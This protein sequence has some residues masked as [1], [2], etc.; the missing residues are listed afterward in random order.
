MI[1]SSRRPASQWLVYAGLAIGSG[2]L[3]LGSALHRIPFEWAETLGFITRAWGVWLQVREN[4]WNWPVQ[5]VSSAIY[6]FVFLQARLY[7]DTLLNVL[8]VGLYVLGWY[9]W[10][11]G[12]E[13][14]TVLHVGRTSARLAIALSV[15][16][17]AGTVAWT[18]VLMR[19]ND[20]APLLDAFTTALSLV[21]LLLTAR[22][23]YESWLV[24]IFVNV[25][26]VG[27]YTN[28]GLY[29]TAVLY[30]IFA[31]LSVAGLFNWRRLLHGQEA[32]GAVP[33]A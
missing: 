12:G 9:W 2:A 21:A 24:W 28:K 4:V 25:V 13:G 32:A 29:L 33:V 17:I 5:L 11:R 30:A 20:S 15:A 6:V 26:F 1:A 27:L 3:A 23:L 7:S 18:G 22:K 19:V 8:Y 31:V 14:S 16:T 10:L